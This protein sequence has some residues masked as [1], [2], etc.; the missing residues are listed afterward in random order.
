MHGGQ[1]ACGL[2]AAHHRNPGVGPC[3]EKTRR[4]RAAAHAIIARAKAAADEHRDLGHLRCRD[5]G[6]Q[7]CAMPGD[8][9]GF[10]F[11]AHHEARDIL[12]KQQRRLSLAG[13]L[14]E[15]GAFNRAFGED[16]AIVCQNRDG[17]APDVREAAHQR[18]AEERF[19][20]VKL[21]AVNNSGDDF[22]D[23]VGRTHILRNDAVKIFGR[24]QGRSGRA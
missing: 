6:H 9:L 13:E 3:E 20:F 15:I 5:G 2:L 18:R 12:E 1:N 23:V 24:I 22:M 11:S 8:A 17:N 10:V 14:N 7:F 19:E 21:A 4:I 16:H